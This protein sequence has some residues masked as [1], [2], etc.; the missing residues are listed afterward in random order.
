MRVLVLCPVLFCVCSWQCFCPI[1]ILVFLM[2]RCSAGAISVSGSFL[3][4]PFAIITFDYRSCVFAVSLQCRCR[5]A[6]VT[7]MTGV[8]ASA[9]VLVIVTVS[10]QCPCKS[11]VSHP[12]IC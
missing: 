11:F 7:L 12:L 1:A 5:F 8:G 2:C 9:L 10:P 3:C 6:R 4:M